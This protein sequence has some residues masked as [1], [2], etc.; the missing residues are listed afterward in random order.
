MKKL[1]LFLLLFV[2]VACGDNYPSDKIVIFEEESARLTQ[3]ART[4]LENI[5]L[6]EDFQ[7]IVTVKDTCRHN[8]YMDIM[9]EEDEIM[10]IEVYSEPLLIKGSLPGVANDDISGRQADKY[11]Q[12]QMNYQQHKDMSLAVI[13]MTE[14]LT[15]IYN[16]AQEHYSGFTKWLAKSGLKGLVNDIIDS[17]SLIFKPYDNWYGRVFV[18]PMYMLA[19]KSIIW[20]G[21]VLKGIIFCA[22]MILMIL[23]GTCALAYMFLARNSKAMGVLLIMSGGILGLLYFLLAFTMASYV[24]A[25]SMEMVYVFQNVYPLENVD[26]LVNIYASQTF[27]SA[28][29]LLVIVLIVAYFFHKYVSTRISLFRLKTQQPDLDVDKETEK[30]LGKDDDSA[31]SMIFMAFCAPLFSSALVTAL[32][33][34]YV[35]SLARKGLMLWSMTYT[36]GISRI[37]DVCKKTLIATLAV[38]AVALLLLVLI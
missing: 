2:A 12:C 4:Q 35:V 17:A 38:G 29:W 33:S 31:T 25:P 18:K 14:C 5:T 11:F 27:R 3:K 23:V 8:D 21:S 28:S 7:L 13:E 32:I 19:A 15:A 36:G 30:D 24:S 9:A 37:Y 34:Y 1:F 26:A 10:F 20:T 6:P 16:D 22:I